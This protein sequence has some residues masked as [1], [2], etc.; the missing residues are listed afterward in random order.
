MIHVLRFLGGEVIYF[1][2]DR[3]KY[4]LQMPGTFLQIKRPDAIW[5][6]R[7]MK[8]PFETYKKKYLKEKRK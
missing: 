5:K 6:H 2:N 3:T 1:V 8:M 4:L 7:T